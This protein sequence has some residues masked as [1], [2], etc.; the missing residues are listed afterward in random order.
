MSDI[1]KLV[2]EA[3]AK[4]PY[5]RNQVRVDWVRNYHPDLRKLPQEQLEYYLERITAD[6]SRHNCML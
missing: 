3:V 4:S 6:E 2:I 5:L 1:Q